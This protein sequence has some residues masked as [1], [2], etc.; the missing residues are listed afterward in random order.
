MPLPDAG[1]G[2]VT[3]IHEGTVTGVQAQPGAIVLTVMLAL[4]PSGGM[5]ALAE[6]IE[7]T[8]AGFEEQLTTG[9]HPVV[10]MKPAISAAEAGWN[11][12][13]MFDSPPMH[14]LQ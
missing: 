5:V 1:P 11:A 6:E 12:S 2:L 9:A 3:V 8:H 13:T 4:P 7:S 14:R 10:D